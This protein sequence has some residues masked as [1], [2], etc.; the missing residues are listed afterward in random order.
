MSLR[1]LPQRFGMAL[2]I[3]IGIGGV[4]GVLVSVL[5]L[6]SGLARTLANTGHANRAIV[7]S[8]NATSELTSSLPR[9]QV[10]AIMDTPGIRLSPDGKPTA[11]PDVL[12]VLKLRS[13]EDLPVNVVLRGIGPEGLT[14]RPEVKLIAGRTFR[15]AVREL[16]AGR[17]A[18]GQFRGLELG[19]VVTLRN[20]EW[21][22][23]GSFASGDALESGLLADAETVLSAAGRNAYQSVT[24]ELEDPQAFDRF[25]QALTGN[26]AL[27]ARVQR[28]SEYYASQTKDRSDGLFRIGYIIGTMMAVGAL[29]GALNAMYSA[30]SARSLEIATLRAIGFGAGAIVIS[31]FIES[32]LLAMAGGI[33]GAGCAWLLFNGHSIDT[34]LVSNAQTVFSSAVTPGLLATGVI[35]ALAIGLVGGLFPAVRAARLPVAAALQVR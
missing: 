15:P 10:L 32:L 3:V 28:E 16:I 11:S 25:T 17:A 2:V 24:A 22:V 23:V 29:F 27:S 5:A 33:L 9:E 35:W 34:N 12:T 31:V 18:Q 21:T 8:A 26:P 4:V 20:S 14:L 19:S 1:C 6:A 7:F 13:T 30:V